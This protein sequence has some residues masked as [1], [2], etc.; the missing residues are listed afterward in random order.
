MVDLLLGAGLVVHALLLV[1]WPR[2]GDEVVPV[3]APVVEGTKRVS[4]PKPFRARKGFREVR[5][6]FED[7]HDPRRVSYA[8]VERPWLALRCCPIHPGRRRGG[9]CR[10][11]RSC[12]MLSNKRS[13]PWVLRAGWLLYSQILVSDLGLA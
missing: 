12:M 13:E 5:R 6:E 11:S 9:G 1:F 7:A 10:R 8:R 2:R 3:E 4:R